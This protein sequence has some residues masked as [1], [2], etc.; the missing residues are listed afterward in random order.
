MDAMTAKMVNSRR[1]SIE[2]LQKEVDELS[3]KVKAATNAATATAWEGVLRV[4]Q[5]RLERLQAELAAFLQPE[6]P[7]TSSSEPPA[8][9]PVHGRANQKPVK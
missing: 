1:K 5:Q 7:G 2:V 3:V 4:K 9:G 6:L 8:A